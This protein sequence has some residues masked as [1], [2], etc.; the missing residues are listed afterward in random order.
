MA[1]IR[2]K[3]NKI[4]VLQSK[5]EILSNQAGIEA[6]FLKYY[7]DI[8]STENNVVHNNLIHDLIPLLV[9]PQDNEF[10]ISISSMEEIKKVVF[11]M[12]ACSVPSLDGYGGHFYQTH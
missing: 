8:F 9:S 10:L 6:Y 2:H 5:D 4:Y 7:V 11:S 3:I 12:N 1:A